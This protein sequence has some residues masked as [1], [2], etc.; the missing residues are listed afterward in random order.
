M[1]VPASAHTLAQGNHPSTA[2][3]ESAFGLRLAIGLLGVL[4][5][6][7]VSGL[8]SRVPG[9][10]LPDLQGALGFGYDDGS[11]LSTA[12]AAGELVAM[13]FASW[14][15]V[16]FSLRRFHLSMLSAALALAAVMP[17]VRELHLLLALRALQ[18]LFSGALVP[19]LMMCAL[20]FLPMS[21]RLHGLAMYALTSTFSPN[22]AL[23]L[24]TLALDRLAD[25]RWAYWHVIPIGIVA[26]AL[27]AWG[28][29]KMPTALPRL[30]DANWAGMALGVPGLTLLV[31]GLDQ[32]VRLDWFHSPIVT[33][34]FLAGTIL[35]ALFMASEW[36]H[37]APFIK[38]QMLQRR[39]LGLGFSVFVL[40]LIIGGTAVTLP[41]NVLG[42]LQGFRLEQSMEIGLIVGLPQLVLGSCVAVLLYQRW[43]DARHIFAAG[44]ACLAIACW[45]G[46]F[47]TSDWM[48]AQFIGPEVLYALGLPMTIIPLLFLATSV[49]QPPEGPYVS[50][51][52]NLFRAL[53]ATL[54]GAVIG[55]LSVVRNRFHT[56]M[57]LDQAGN[58]AAR[59]PSDDA[60]WASIASNVAQQ[61][62][63]LSTADVYRV[64]GLLA[65]LLIPVVLNLQY[66]PAPTTTASPITSPSTTPRTSAAS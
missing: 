61:A 21:L 31:V 37:P 3:Q 63:V 49:V 29:P 51:I 11:W 10:V 1:T 40:L 57:L 4:L 44:L 39:N 65:L 30:K 48:V 32:G 64:F 12:Y 36:R 20:R 55:Q 59:L 13:P 66:I 60:R 34:S 42:Q 15:A 2:A 47:I 16:T 9:L 53:S 38:L 6:A 54:G 45:L 24:A 22:I 41:A 33:A 43:I 26:M 62:G 28:L 58:L 46:S 35:T 5:A 25:W 27:V 8:N 52:V 18:G 7:M 17:F 56:E 19:L 14:F 50:G 23:W